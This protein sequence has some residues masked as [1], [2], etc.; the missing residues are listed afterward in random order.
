MTAAMPAIELDDCR[1]FA[2]NE[3][4]VV[5]RSFLCH[6]IRSK[7]FSLSSKIRIVRSY[8]CLASGVQRRQKNDPSADWLLL[9]SLHFGQVP[10]SLGSINI[11]TCPY[12]FASD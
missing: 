8:R 3:K 11:D 4:Q 5:Y 12:D 10:R 6:F 1:S 7:I 9:R 2:E